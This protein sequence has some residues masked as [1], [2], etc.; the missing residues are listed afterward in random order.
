MKEIV[1][2]VIRDPMILL[3]VMGA[4]LTF[5]LLAFE[6]AT[7][8]K[9][10]KYLEKALTFLIFFV[11]SY[12]QIFPFKLFHLYDLT[13]HTIGTQAILMRV[14][15]YSFSV[16]VL[17][18]R[19]SDFLQSTLLLF[20]DPFL[21][22]F[23]LIGC[24][25]FFWSETPDLTLRNSFILLL[26]SAIAAHIG[27]RFTWSEI[28]HFLR[29]SN[30]LTAILS[31]FYAI[32]IPSVG[33]SGKGWKGILKHGNPLGALMAL[34]TVIL[35]LYVYDKPK[36]RWMYLVVALIS[37][38]N[39]QKTNSAGSKVVLVVLISELIFLKFIKNLNFKLALSAVAIFLAVSIA[40][41]IL[42][43]ENRETIIVDILGKDMEL[44]GR[45]PLW[46]RLMGGI[47]AQPIFGY[48]VSG[49]WQH[50]REAENPAAPFATNDFGWVA[51]HAHNGFLDVLLDFGLVG[52]LF[53]L[54]SFFKN[55]AISVL[56][57]IRGKDSDAIVPL[58][59]LTFIIMTNISQSDLV[60]IQHLWFYY[61]ILTVRVTLDVT[62]KNVS[63]YKSS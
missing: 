6:Y 43:I 25:S 12:P 22:T 10:P 26:L 20:L 40:L 19:Y 39:L 32:A 57:M 36:E 47:A 51:H 46:T 38:I 15:P 35:I 5:F 29:L 28:C 21:G 24:L 1:K 54:I 3:L 60:G 31:F 61:V 53:F 14:I 4:G 48:G 63:G 62:G 2:E 44:N 45:I 59:I 16:F 9:R 27:K 11:S 41:G 23:L 13:K 18:N 30:A 49:F 17:K 42:V 7:F 37:L 33:V 58:L 34:T 8:G 56:F 55:I 50:W 52:G